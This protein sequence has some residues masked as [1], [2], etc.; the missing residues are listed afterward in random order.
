MICC[1]VVLHGR[2]GSSLHSHASNKVSKVVVCDW[3]NTVAGFSEDDLHCCG[4]RGR[5]STLE[6]SIIILRGRRSALDVPCAVLLRF[7]L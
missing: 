2:R 1:D 3:R 7:A 5:H 4:F 6:T